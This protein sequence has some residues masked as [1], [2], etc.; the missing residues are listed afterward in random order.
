MDERPFGS[1]P[2]GIDPDSGLRIPRSSGQDLPDTFRPGQGQIGPGIS[3]DIE[4]DNTTAYTSHNGEQRTSDFAYT[5]RTSVGPNRPPPV[6]KAKYP[7]YA[8][9]SVRLATFREWPST[10]TQQPEDMAKAG[11][12]YSGIDLLSMIKGRYFIQLHFE[13]GFSF[14]FV[15][16]S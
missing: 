16:G 7:Q 10:L 3:N 8:V 12:Y 2:P 1:R 15:M 4:T 13:V 5:T 9:E 6:R 11:F 14:T